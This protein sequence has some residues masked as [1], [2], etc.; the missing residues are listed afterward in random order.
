MIIDANLNE[1][2]G[3]FII[4]LEYRLWGVRW[5]QEGRSQHLQVFIDHDN[6]IGVDDCAHVSRHLSVWLDVE[7]SLT[8][9]YVL[10]V[11][12]P[13]AD[14]LLFGAE[15]FQHYAAQKVT[16]R[17]HRSVLNKRTLSATIISCDNDAVI[18][19]CDGKDEHQTVLLR[20]IKEA[21]LQ[22]DDNRLYKKQQ[23]TKAGT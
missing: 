14:R 19:A 5:H 13:G 8:S 4:G 6:G 23:Q 21:R 16:L 12:S 2:I 1:A 20:D 9:N 11:S 3:K 10:E 22:L 17:L 7:S 15:H 18:V